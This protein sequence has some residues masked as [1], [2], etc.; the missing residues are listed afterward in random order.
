MCSVITCKSCFFAGDLTD[1]K[2]ADNMGSA[3]YEQEWINYRDSL[4][5]CNLG[6]HTIWLDV[7]GN[8]GKWVL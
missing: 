1:A 3:Q 7:R 8:H 2:A 4:N 6:N 5:K